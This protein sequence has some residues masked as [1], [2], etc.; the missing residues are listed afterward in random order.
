MLVLSLLLCLY[1]FHVKADDSDDSEYSIVGT[2]SSK[3][4][5]VFTGPGFYDPIDELLIEPALPGISYSFTEDGYFEEA[6][7]QVTSNAKNHSC[8]AAALIYQHGSYEI[9]S[10][11]SLVL[12][13][14]SVDGRQLLSEPC[15]D[16]GVS[17]YSRYEQTELFAEYAV[18]LD[19]YHGQYRLN[20]YEWD[21]TPVQ[22]L[23]IAYKPPMMLPTITLNPTT[24][25]DNQPTVTGNSK[26]SLRNII[27][28][29]FENKE[30]TNAVRKSSLNVDFWWWS[31]VGLISLG[32]V[33][34]VYL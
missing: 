2:W 6:I 5:T 29:S 8:P 7:Y 22:P 17:T 25:T 10:N 4:N 3:S 24:S 15:E 12:T 16:G 33:F 27:K 9:L 31:S 13:P 1:V 14:I 20:L 23:Y 11:G 32:S 26:R 21:G 18:V 30:R 28:R 34:Y 19:A